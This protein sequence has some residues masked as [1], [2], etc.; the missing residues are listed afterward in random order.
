MH[1]RDFRQKYHTSHRLHK[2]LNSMFLFCGQDKISVQ[3]VE[4][5]GFWKSSVLILERFCRSY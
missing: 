4:G 2:A 5:L 1:L 3:F